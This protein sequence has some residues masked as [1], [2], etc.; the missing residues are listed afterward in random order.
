[1]NQ[2]KRKKKQKTIHKSNLVINEREQ[3]TNVG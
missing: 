3:K 2:S 1:M